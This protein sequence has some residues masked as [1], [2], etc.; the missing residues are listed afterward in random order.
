MI[1]DSK[2]WR[3]KRDTLLQEWMMGDQAA[4]DFLHTVFCAAE[5]WDDIVDGDYAKAKEAV[6]HTMLM[7]LLDLPANP[8][9]ERTKTNCAPACCS[10]STLGKTA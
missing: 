9:I 1:F 3:K 2:E 5:L 8:S 6:S 7:L 10:G 4:I